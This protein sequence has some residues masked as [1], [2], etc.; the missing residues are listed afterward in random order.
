LIQPYLGG[1]EILND[2]AHRHYR[3]VINFGGMTE[4]EARRWPQLM[5]VIEAK[6]KPHRLRQS[7]AGARERWWQFARRCGAFQS[8][9]RGLD[10]CLVHPNL[11]GHLAFAFVSR[12]VVVGAPHNLLT[13]G[14]YST[15]ALLQSRTHEVW[16]R[17]FGSSMKDDLRYTPSD[18]FQTFPF[19]RK[20]REIGQ[21]E[22][23]G[24]HYYEFRADLM[25]RS[26]EGLT[27]TYNRFHDPD[28]RCPEILRL[29]RLHA[30]MDRAVLDAYDWTDIPTDCEFLLDY[31]EDEDDEDGGRAGHRRRPWRY[32][33]PDDVRDEVL[34]RL[35]ALNAERAEEERLAGLV[36]GGRRSAGRASTKR[37]AAGG[38]FPEEQ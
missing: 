22:T 21:L 28:E 14:D 17:L 34:A 13:F 32:R 8:A 36:T 18:C 38:L 3:Y 23:A 4:S 29:R 26:A 30:E 10:Q 27:K 35:L 24:R 33:W 9:A 5:A 16:A 19:A 11:S 7:D 6:A 1:E 25:V 20:W 12:D 2:P 15:F 31:E 37:G